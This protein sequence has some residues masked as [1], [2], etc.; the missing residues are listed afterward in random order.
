MFYVDIIPRE[1]NKQIH[2]SEKLGNSIIKVEPPHAKRIV[3]QYTRCQ[4][5]RHTKPQSK[6][7][8]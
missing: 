2:H 1:N 6:R 7:L 3:P 5:Y 4:A 8:Q